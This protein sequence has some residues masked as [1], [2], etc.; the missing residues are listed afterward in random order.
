[1]TATHYVPWCLSRHCATTL[2]GTMKELHVIGT[3]RCATVTALERRENQCPPAGSFHRPRTHTHLSECHC[4]YRLVH[5]QLRAMH[6]AHCNQTS[7]HSAP[8]ATNRPYPHFC[9]RRHRRSYQQNHRPR[10]D[11]RF[12]ARHANVSSASSGPFSSSGTRRTSFHPDYDS[13][14][15]SYI[16]YTP[17]LIGISTE[18]YGD[19]DQVLQRIASCR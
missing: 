1:M 8:R 16:I 5:R 19:A 14:G 10:T 15:E 18:A 12:S 13:G 3:E 6:H 7:S 4:S 9:C 17:P 2:H 11:T